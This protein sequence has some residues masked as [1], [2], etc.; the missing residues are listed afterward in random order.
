MSVHDFCIISLI[1]DG[2]WQG[3][4]PRVSPGFGGWHSS[5]PWGAEGEAEETGADQNPHCQIKVGFDS[6]IAL[7]FS[8]L[9]CLS[10]CMF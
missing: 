2:S 10:V 4:D 9:C 1:A 5:E 3:C 8:C 7:L 6:D